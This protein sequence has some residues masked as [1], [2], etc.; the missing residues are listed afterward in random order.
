MAVIPFNNREENIFWLQ[1]MGDNCILLL[2]AIPPDEKEQVAILQEY[3]QQFDALV[4]R[5]LVDLKGEQLQQF[6]R[7]AYT[8]TQ[9]MRRCYLNLL[10]MQVTKGFFILMKPSIINNMVDLA[11]RYLSILTAFLN[12]Q[13]PDFDPTEQ[14]IYWF[15]IFVAQG[16]YIADNI[17]YYQSDLRSAANNY[18]QQMQNQCNFA[19][20]LKG[21]HRIG[22]NNFPIE[23][24]HRS[25]VANIMNDYSDFIAKVMQLVQQ[26]R[27]P[28]SLSLGYM[29]RSNRML[30]YFLRQLADYA[31]TLPP[32]CDPTSPRL[33]QRTQKDP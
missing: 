18:A 1:L 27:I 29:D 5:A 20:E 15:P 3:I 10:R 23:R 26:N 32:A 14:E 19:I 28:G 24:E 2:D 16:R 11:D 30:C 21:I 31:N 12:N 22:E 13:K 17:G 33:Q 9:K 25:V 4:A 7:E 8:E 6:N